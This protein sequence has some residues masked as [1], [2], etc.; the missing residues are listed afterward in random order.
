MNTCQ[1]LPFQ[2]FNSNLNLKRTRSGTQVNGLFCIHNTHFLRST[3][4]SLPFIYS[5]SQGSHH[6]DTDGMEV[7]LILKLITWWRPLI[8]FIFCPFTHPAGNQTPDN[9]PKAHVLNDL[10]WLCN[11]NLYVNIK[12]ILFIVLYFIY[13]ILFALSDNV[14]KLFTISQYT[15]YQRDIYGILKM[16]KIT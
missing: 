9:Q 8:S 1:F 14:I 5:C 3:K 2:I 10:P 16:L 11:V 7:P 6:K 13:I 12:L 4:I 15:L